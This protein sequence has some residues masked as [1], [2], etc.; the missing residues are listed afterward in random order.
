MLLPPPPPPAG[1][2]CLARPC[3]LR[4]RFVFLFFFGGLSAVSSDATPLPLTTSSAD[5]PSDAS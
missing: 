4:L 1:R 3:F 2:A 5:T